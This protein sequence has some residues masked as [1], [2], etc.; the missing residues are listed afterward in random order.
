M[1]R[2]VDVSLA[3]DADPFRMQ[4]AALAAECAALP[5]LAASVSFHTQLWPRLLAAPPSEARAAL[6]PL[7]QPALFLQGAASLLLDFGDADARTRRPDAYREAAEQAAQAP[8]LRPSERLLLLSRFDWPAFVA[9]GGAPASLRSLIAILLNDSTLHPALAPVAAAVFG[10]AALPVRLDLLRTLLAAPAAASGDLPLGSLLA[11]DALTPDDADAY[12]ALAASADPL[13]ALRLALAVPHLPRPRLAAY[14][15]PLA[16]RLP[17]AVRSR[18]AAEAL[19]A[20]LARGGPDE[21]MAGLLHAALPWL[22]RT[23]DASLGAP[24]TAPLSALPWHAATFHLASLAP[25]AALLLSPVAP[26]ALHLL[27]LLRWPP[28][29][30]PPA[31]REAYAVDLLHLAAER[32]VLDPAAP[33][34]DVD[35][36]PDADADA[37]PLPA[38]AAAVRAVRW[39]DEPAWSADAAAARMQS[40]GGG[41]VWRQVSAGRATAS[42]VPAALHLLLHATPIVAPGRL[43][44][45]AAILRASSRVAYLA[46]VEPGALAPAWRLSHAQ[47]VEVLSHMARL[48]QGLSARAAEQREAMPALAGLWAE[49]W[50]RGLDLV[51]TVEAV[52]RRAADPPDGTLPNEKIRALLAHMASTL[53][54]PVLL[55]LMPHSAR[56][57]QWLEELVRAYFVWEA[58]EPPR[59]AA[60]IAALPPRLALPPPDVSHAYPLLLAALLRRAL[61]ASA[62]QGAADFAADAERWLTVAAKCEPLG[63]YQLH[64]VP[65]WLA[66]L[67]VFAD[68]RAPA[69]LAPLVGRLLERHAPPKASLFARLTTDEQPPHPPTYLAARAALVYLARL[70]AQKRARSQAGAGAGRE[71]GAEEAAQLERLMALRPEFARY[72][73]FFAEAEAFLSPLCDLP[74]FAAALCN[75]LFPFAP[76]L[77]HASSG[78]A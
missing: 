9:A 61:A 24:L 70:A 64:L 37:A 77:L 30:S 35:A 47:Q 26:F 78:H 7:V 2:L 29:W 73:A 13:A 67:A 45:Y 15:E 32:H 43:S 58:D 54:A 38:H 31:E 12:H 75:T 50:D 3:P 49:A 10:A 59:L 76:Y 21:A 46:L 72:T 71:S 69:A 11:A 19:G 57:P 65:L 63:H 8:S 23:A 56:A 14:L 51:Q 33:L 4:F 36:R 41:G 52:E 5:R 44:A 22:M 53:P 17:T 48:M 16:R 74:S 18:A 25:F 20:L 40:A 1:L 39:A 34:P 6:L 66:A 68:P 28:D 62:G 60:L 55:A 42:A 27:A